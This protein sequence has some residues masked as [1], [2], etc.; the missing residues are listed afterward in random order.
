MGT[1]LVII[2]LILFSA[3]E[4]GTMRTVALGLQGSAASWGLF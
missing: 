2:L 3:G 1:I 4:V